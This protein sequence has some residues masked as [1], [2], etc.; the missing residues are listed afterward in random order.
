MIKRTLEPVLARAAKHYPIVTLTGPRQ[1]GKTTLA[2]DAFKGIDFWRTL[3]G[4][5]EAPAALIHG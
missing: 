1:S 3:P 4:Q 2:S 5:A